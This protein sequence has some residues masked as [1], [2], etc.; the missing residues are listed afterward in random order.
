M[1]A[2][3]SRCYLCIESAHG[4]EDNVEITTF[5]QRCDRS[6]LWQ[7]APQYK[8]APHSVAFRNVSHHMQMS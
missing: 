8:S 4:L 2:A 1:H 7:A 3:E 5:H 6:R